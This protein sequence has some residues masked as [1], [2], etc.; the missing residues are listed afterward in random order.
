MKVK[1]YS[2]TLTTAILLTLL[3]I[4]AAEASHK[5]SQD[6]DASKTYKGKCVAC[7]GA[8]AEKKFDAT[9]SDD[10]QVQVILKGKKLEKPP[11][12]P[13]YGDKG[14]NAEQAR[15][16]LDYMKSIRQ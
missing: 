13:S 5:R 4:V 1:T 3:G 8:K 14:I 15:A 12:M 6:F 16:L 10:E 11:N 7:H 9:K 2:I